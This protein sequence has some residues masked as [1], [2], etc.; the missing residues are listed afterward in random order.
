MAILDNTS[1]K[2]KEAIKAINKGMAVLDKERRH[3]NNDPITKE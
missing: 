2:N 1:E 3:G